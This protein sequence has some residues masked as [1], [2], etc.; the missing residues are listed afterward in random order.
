MAGEDAAG[1][2]V[3]GEG[4]GGEDEDG[5]QRVDE[6]AEADLVLVVLG[7]VNAEPG[8]EH[9][10]PARGDE[11]VVDLAVGA[12]EGVGEVEEEAGEAAEGEEGVDHVGGDGGALAVGV[13]RRQHH[14]EG[15]EGSGGEEV[16]KEGGFRERFLHAACGR[17]RGGEGC[18]RAA[19]R[20]GRAAAAA[21][22]GVQRMCRF[23]YRFAPMLISPFF[24]LLLRW[25]VSGFL[26][27]SKE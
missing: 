13:D 6:V 8:L 1:D 21:A 18:R 9:C 22:A 16:G 17:R 3:V 24:F 5:H 14:L 12:L 19:E 23:E 4:N 27:R 7:D 15:E 11:A 2:A 26:Q 25:F 10:E 20:R